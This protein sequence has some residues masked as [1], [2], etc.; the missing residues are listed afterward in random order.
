MGGLAA[1]PAM[2]EQ[3]IQI[4]ALINSATFLAI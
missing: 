2:K 4:S 3:K 1:F